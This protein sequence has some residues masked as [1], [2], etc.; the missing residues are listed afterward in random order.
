MNDSQVNKPVLQSMVIR[1]ATALLAVFLTRLFAKYLP[2]ETAAEL[3]K[4]SADE[5]VGGV[6]FGLY[7]LIV[8]G[9]L[10]L[11][12]VILSLG[13]VLALAG[14]GASAWPAVCPVE[15]GK[16][17][18]TCAQEIRFKATP[19]ANGRKLVTPSCDGQALPI[20]LDVGRVEV[21]Q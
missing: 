7:T 9:R 12:T 14:C 3:A 17:R 13:A 1:A 5:I 19:T 4:G 8:W 2:G 11:R 6:A 21:Q 20:E 16:R 10:R 18:C 15:D